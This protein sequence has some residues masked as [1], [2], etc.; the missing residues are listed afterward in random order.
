MENDENKIKQIV[1]SAVGNLR[2]AA[3]ANL[4]I[5]SPVITP[6]GSTILPVSQ[7]A[8]GFFAGGGEYGGSKHCKAYDDRFA[9]G[10]GGGATL[11]PLGFLVLTKDSVH[12][13]RTQENSPAE[14]LADLAK[15]IFLWLNQK[16]Q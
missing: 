15:D 9:G 8:L 10:S 6:D 4:M 2:Q 5:G 3:E 11:T 14:K 7:V 12:L 13:I 16:K 1:D